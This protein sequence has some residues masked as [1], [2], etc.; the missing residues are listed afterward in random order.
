MGGIFTKYGLYAAILIFLANLVNLILNL[1]FNSD[2]TI[3]GEKTIKALVDY[4]TLTITVVIVAAPEGLPLTVAIALAYSVGR[5]KDDKILVRT[6]NSPEK[7]GSVEEICT[8]KTATLT[9]NDMRVAMFYAQ[10]HL[11]RV[12]RK[13]T[14]F[15]CELFD[16]VISLLIE[17][18]LFNSDA[19]IEM[20]DHAFYVP[21]GSCTDVGM[22]KF[23]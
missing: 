16:N 18:I 15:N 23:L 5:M 21:V 1:S 8:G 22:I 13:N 10:A 17:S 7:M 2:Y 14:L 4:I 6:L 3:F 12:T 9:K 11:V 20:D 19:R